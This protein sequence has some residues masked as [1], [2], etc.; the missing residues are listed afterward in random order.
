[1]WAGLQITVKSINMDIYTQRAGRRGLG[2]R[3]VPARGR[4]PE[5]DGLITAAESAPARRLPRSLT[6]AA[7]CGPP[8]LG[9]PAELHPLHDPHHPGAVGGQADV[10]SRPVA[11]GTALAPA[12]DAHQQPGALHLA[13]Q[14]APGVTLRRGG[15]VRDPC[16]SGLDRARTRHSVADGSLGW[17]ARGHAPPGRCWSASRA[18]EHWAGQASGPLLVRST[19]CLT[20][21]LTAPKPGSTAARLTGRKPRLRRKYWLSP[22]GIRGQQTRNYNRDLPASRPGC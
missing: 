12:D 4:P 8:P 13:H 3:S 21:S 11:L 2:G 14:G 15:K 17:G 16:G 22:T 20:F 5:A 1:M 10:D 18:G 9:V 19:L 6:R 7:P